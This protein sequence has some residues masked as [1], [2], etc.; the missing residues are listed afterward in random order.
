M[1]LPKMYEYINFGKDIVCV[2]YPEVERFGDYAE[3]Y[4][5]AD[6]YCAAI[7]AIM[8]RPRRKYSDGQRMKMLEESSWH[9]RVQPILK[10]LGE[11]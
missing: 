11:L 6:E 7:E 10:A 5:G 2:R 4:N 9:S 8:V 3:L 1:S